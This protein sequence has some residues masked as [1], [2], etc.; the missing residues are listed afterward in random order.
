M[1]QHP[2]FLFFY[3]ISLVPA[4]FILVKE[5]LEHLHGEIKMYLKF[6]VLC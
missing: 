5:L 4:I 1:F 2:Y 3:P 6:Y